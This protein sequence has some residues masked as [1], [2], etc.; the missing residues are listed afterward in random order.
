MLDHRE[1]IPEGLCSIRLCVDGDSGGGVSGGA[2]ASLQ[3]NLAQMTHKARRG[4]IMR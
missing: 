3:M 4:P 2:Q 1:V